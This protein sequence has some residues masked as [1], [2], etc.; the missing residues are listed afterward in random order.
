MPYLVP[1]ANGSDFARF[2]IDPTEKTSLYFT[3]AEL[4]RNSNDD[5]F[6][7]FGKMWAISS[8]YRGKDDAT[9]E[10]FPWVFFEL[11][12]KQFKKTDWKTK[13]E[14]TIEPTAIEQY[15]YQHLTGQGDYNPTDF[16]TG[17]KG[18]ITLGDYSTLI[19]M[20]PDISEE[21]R[22][23]K[24]EE[25]AQV[26]QVE[27]SEE[28]K[29]KKKPNIGAKQGQGGYRGSSAQKE[30]E[31]LGDRTNWLKSFLDPD[32]TEGIYSDAHVRVMTLLYL[33][34]NGTFKPQ[35][36]RNYAALILGGNSLI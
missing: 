25:M 19:E 34:E 22:A 32:N 8:E 28:F 18:R 1:P 20:L 3:E 29:G 17:F 11:H 30:I 9:I 16:S 2:Y 24:L 13:A 21:K 10:K 7:I 4:A 36:Y 33:M 12:D 15:L 31:R 35:H 27:L 14:T 6:I 26:E 5:G 23:I